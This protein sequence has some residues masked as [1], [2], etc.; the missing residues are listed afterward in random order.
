MIL[1]VIERCKNNPT[2]LVD[3]WYKEVLYTLESWF[4]QIEEKNE[5]FQLILPLNPWNLD[6]APWLKKS[7]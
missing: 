3:R 1:D 7:S 4:F 6:R 2:F 5:N